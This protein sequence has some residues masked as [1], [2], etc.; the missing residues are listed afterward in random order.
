[1]ITPAANESDVWSSQ[2]SPGHA[3]CRAHKGAVLEVLGG[4]W[5]Y[6]GNLGDRFRGS[7]DELPMS[8]RCLCLAGS[9]SHRLGGVCWQCHFA[10]GLCGSP[11]RG[12]VAQAEAGEGGWRS[13]LRM[14][15][16]NFQ[17]DHGVLLRRL[18]MQA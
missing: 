5:G 3:G 15:V 16:S 17:D 1:M 14:A 8:S 11:R 10:A 12:Y 7:L 13:S 9:R 18:V 4:L 2:G 6:G